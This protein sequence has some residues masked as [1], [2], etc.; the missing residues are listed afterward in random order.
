[1]DPKSVDNNGI[2]T[3]S[4]ISISRSSPG[5]ILSRHAR[6]SYSLISS[7]IDNG[8]RRSVRLSIK[9]PQQRSSSSTEASVHRTI[10]GGVV[11][12]HSPKLNTR[13]RT[14]A[15]VDTHGIPV[16]SSDC[17]ASTQHGAGDDSNTS[18]PNPLPSDQSDDDE[19]V[20]GDNVVIKRKHTGLATRSEVLS[21][22]SIEADGYKCK[23][24]NKVKPRSIQIFLLRR[25]YWCDACSEVVRVV[26]SRRG[27]VL[28]EPTESQ[29]TELDA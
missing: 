26:S 3:A 20:S 17:S 2:D 7:L 10:S 4:S 14:S 12:T 28:Y 29:R 16:N 9:S 15:S 13:K 23:L 18:G 11:S 21:Y 19:M 8:I 24:C 5:T 25:L 22:Y 1:M 6:T 27:S